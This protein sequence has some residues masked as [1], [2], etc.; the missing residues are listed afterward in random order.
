MTSPE[1]LSDGAGGGVVVDSAAVATAV[2]EAE[3]AGAATG[4]EGGVAEER[5]RIFAATT[6]ATAPTAAAPISGSLL[7][8]LL[9][10]GLAECVGGLRGGVADIRGDAGGVGTQAVQ[11]V[12]HLGERIALAS[13]RVLDQGFTSGWFP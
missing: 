9:G 1:P 7:E 12:E 13:E 10:R 5:R 3:A 6:S 11:G 2:G 8:V 4:G